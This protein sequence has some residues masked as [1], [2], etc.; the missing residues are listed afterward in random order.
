MI[1][2]M[3]E[4][5]MAQGEIRKMKPIVATTCLFGAALRM[6]H[7][8]LDETV[9]GPLEPYTDEIWSNSWRGVTA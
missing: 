8:Y 6:I 7:L 3:V 5:G 4:K 2:A 1:K 9:K